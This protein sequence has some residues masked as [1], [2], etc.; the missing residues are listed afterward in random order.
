[1]KTMEKTKAT[2]ENQRKSEENSS[3]AKKITQINNEKRR[4]DNN[5][6]IDSADRIMVNN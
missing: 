4:N 2:V 5:P 3:K 1:M 6:K